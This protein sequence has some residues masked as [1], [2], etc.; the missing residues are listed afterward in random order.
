MEPQE[1]KISEKI[2]LTKLSDTLLLLTVPGCLMQI[3]C[4]DDGT[5]ILVQ[6]DDGWE[7]GKLDIYK[8]EFNTDLRVKLRKPK[9]G[10]SDG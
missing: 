7:I 4:E 5:G 9:E 8:K 2:A 10:V 6:S 1:M 3:N